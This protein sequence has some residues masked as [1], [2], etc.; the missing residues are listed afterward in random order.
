VHPSIQLEL[1]DGKAFV[2]DEKSGRV[3]KHE[4]PPK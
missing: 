2:T 3:I 1:D 4:T